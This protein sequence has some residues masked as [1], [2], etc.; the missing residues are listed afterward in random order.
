MKYRVRV[1]ETAADDGTDFFS[2]GVAI[3]IPWGSRKRGLGR[4]AAHR[5]AE[6]GG[7]SRFSATLDSIAAELVAVEASWRRAADKFTSYRDHLIPSGRA[8]LE[9]TLNDFSVGKAEFGLT[10]AS[11]L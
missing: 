3:P 8:A 1:A 7:Q 10:R 6:Q 4:E 2:A 11:F 5:A 9:T